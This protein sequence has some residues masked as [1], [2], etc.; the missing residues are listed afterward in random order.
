M[1]RW[2][3]LRKQS[4]FPPVLFFIYLVV[5]LLMSGI[6]TGLIVGMNKAGWNDK[7]Q[8]LLPIL[9]WTLVAVMLT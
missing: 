1:K 9:Y 6:H 7:V 2:N 3:E 5:L 4:L 8:M